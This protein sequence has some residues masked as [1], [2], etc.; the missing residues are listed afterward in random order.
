MKKII[1]SDEAHFQFNEY[2]N[3]QNFQIWGNENLRVS[4]EKQMHPE[5]ITIWSGFWAS[6]VITES[7]C[8]GQ[9]EG[10]EGVICMILYFTL[11]P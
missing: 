6:G 9:L 1:F 5:R 11:K 10:P 7:L 4:M 8:V 3:K 2:V